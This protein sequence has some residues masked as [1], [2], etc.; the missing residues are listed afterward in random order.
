MTADV[1]DFRQHIKGKAVPLDYVAGVA[2]PGLLRELHA[3]ILAVRDV[4]ETLEDVGAA[5][6][7]IEIVGE[8]LRKFHV[9][10][11]LAEP[12]HWIEEHLGCDQGPAA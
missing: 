2:V 3:A 5:F 11:Y 4:A 7:D 12:L 6:P 9:I 8:M 10:S 1:I